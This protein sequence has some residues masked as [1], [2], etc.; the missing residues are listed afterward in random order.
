MSVARGFGLNGKSFYTNVAKPMQVNLNFTVTP[1]NG[2][3]ITSLK[4]NGYVENV[5]MHTSTTP[6]GNNGFTNPNPAVGY[7][8]VQLKQNFNYFLGLT[9]AFNPPNATATKVD[10]SALTVGQVYVISTLGDAAA[11]VWTAIGVPTGVTPAVGVVFTALTVGAGANTSTSRVMLPSVAGVDFTEVI[12]V[13]N[14]M[15]NSN[16]AKNAGQWVFVQF[17][18]SIVTMDAFTPAGTNSAPTFT[19]SALATHSHIL[20][21]KNAAVADGATTR[22]NA[23]T[24]LLGANTGSDITVAGGGA[25]GGVAAVTAGTPAGTVAAPTFTGTPAT[26]TG[27]VTQS[28]AA[29]TTGT[30]ISLSL[31]FDG[32]TVTIDGL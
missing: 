2:T 26:L 30:I 19:G 27:T 12:G 22:V 24:N 28:V 3:G 4:S 16:I 32:S 7:G 10:N 23:G 15:T 14:T 29:P 8:I 17:S 31:Y 6:S 11:S 5:F 1:T 21:L 25:N 9:S 18:K 13:T 20:N